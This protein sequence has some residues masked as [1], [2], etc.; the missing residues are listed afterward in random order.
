[1]RE[2]TSSKVLTKW[3]ELIL[4]ANRQIQLAKQRI[5]TLRKTVKSLEQV[6]DSGQQWPMQSSAR[7]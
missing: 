3:D 2:K 4:D 6:R 1:M 5:A 7:K